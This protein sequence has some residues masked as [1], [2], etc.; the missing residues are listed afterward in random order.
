MPRGSASLTQE[1]LGHLLQALP[2]WK[3]AEDNTRIRRR[4]R[5]D[6][7][8]ESIAFLSR[9]APVADAEDHHPDIKL[10]MYRWLEVDYRTNSI[11]GLT[12]NDLIMAAKTELLYREFTA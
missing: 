4:F 3:L 9:L 12:R 1:E 5:F 10:T 2:E 7:F 6:G 8:S 11:G